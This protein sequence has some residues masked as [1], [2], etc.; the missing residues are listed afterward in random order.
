[1]K[2][3]RLIH[4][5]TSN[6]L[7]LCNKNTNVFFVMHPIVTTWHPR[8]C[9]VAATLRPKQHNMALYFLVYSEHN[10]NTCNTI[11]IYPT[12]ISM[13]EYAFRLTFNGCHVTIISSPYGSLRGGLVNIT[14]CLLLLLSFYFALSIYFTH[15]I[16]LV[17]IYILY[18]STNAFFVHPPMTVMW[19]PH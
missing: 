12:I 11:S 10:Q 3:F 13:H 14:L 8:Q 2:D 7:H 16:Q 1:M 18:K 9:H 17:Y 15:A 6:L 19:H 4:T 5:Y